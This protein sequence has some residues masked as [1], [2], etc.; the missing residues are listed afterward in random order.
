MDDA[1]HANAGEAVEIYLPTS[2]VTL[3]G[4]ESTDDHGITSWLWTAKESN[5]DHTSMNG[6][7]T[8]QLSI[9]EIQKPGLYVYKLTVED[10][11]G[12]TDRHG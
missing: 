8:N 1:P 4:N 5:P 2:S 11:K 6:V 7:H 10:A 9:N 3:H 12:Q